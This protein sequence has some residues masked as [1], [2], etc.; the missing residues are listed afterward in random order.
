MNA[1]E[2]ILAVVIIVVAAVQIVILALL[3]RPLTRFLA[4]A[5]RIMDSIE[6]ER[7]DVATA[8]RGLRAAAEV[9]SQEITALVTTVRTTTD[10]ISGI[11][12]TSSREISDLIHRTVGVAER[13]IEETDRALDIARD[14]VTE[15]GYRFDRTVLEPARIALAVGVGIRKGIETM[16]GNARGR[17]ELVEPEEDGRHT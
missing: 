3:Y 14:R 13:Q 9:S 7:K 11:A 6:P 10:E 1:L 2:I 12:R 17:R 15:I 4:R 5:D 8:V 16:F